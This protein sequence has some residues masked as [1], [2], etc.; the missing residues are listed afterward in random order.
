MAKTMVFLAGCEVCDVIRFLLA[1]G[2]AAEIY[3][4]VAT[5]WTFN[6]I[7]DSKV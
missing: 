6:I 5:V 4:V 7:R 2:P 1:K 3:R